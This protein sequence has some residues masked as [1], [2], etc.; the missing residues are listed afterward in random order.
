[1][2]SQPH[3]D[4][5]SVLIEA[6]PLFLTDMLGIGMLLQRGL[7]QGYGLDRSNS[8]ITAVRSSDQAMVVETQNHFYT[9]RHREHRPAPRCRSYRATCPTRAAFWCR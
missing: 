3:P 7:R 2:V 1:V 4:R 9:A 8:V 5:K 6:S